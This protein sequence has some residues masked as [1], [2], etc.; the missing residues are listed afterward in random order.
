MEELIKHSLELNPLGV[1]S[2]FFLGLLFVV[3]LHN[4]FFYRY[5]KD[6]SFLWYS[7]YIFLIICDQILVQWNVY[8]INVNNEWLSFTNPFHFSFEWLFSSAYVIFVIE[9]GGLLSLNKKVAKLIKNL[10]F[11]S[12]F[13]LFPFLI[14]DLL[15]G[16]KLITN[17]F[18]YVQLP[19]L[20]ILSVVVFTQLFK[21]KNR[22]KKLCITW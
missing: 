12:L 6:K 2:Y 13:F 21:V 11:G 22:D 20:L 19:V 3:L 7:V 15:Y 1:Y 9:F 17:S 18:L 4:I 14:I 16:T 8:N 10:V 5:Y